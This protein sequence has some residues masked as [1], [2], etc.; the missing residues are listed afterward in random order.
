LISNANSCTLT[1]SHP[2]ISPDIFQH[3][4]PIISCNDYFSQFMHDQLNNRINLLKHGPIVCRSLKYDIVNSGDVRQY[5]TRVMRLTRGRLL[6]QDD[7][8]DW[9]TSKFLQLDQYADQKCFGDPTLVDKDDAVFHL[10]WT[11]NIKALD[12][13]KKALCVCDGSSRSGSLKILDEVYAN[14]IGQTS[15]RLFYTVLAAKNLLIFGSDVCNAFAEAPLPKQGF[16]I[17]PDRAFHKW[18]ENHLRRPPIP[19]GHVIPILLA[20]QGHPESPRLWEKHANAIL[21]ELGLTSTTHKP[22]LYSG[23]INS[24]CIIF[25]RQVH[26]FAIAAPNDWNANILLDMLNEKLTMPIKRQGPLDMF[27]GVDV[28]QTKDYVKVDYHTYINRMCSKYLTSWLN[29]VPLL[30]TRPTPL[31]L[32]GDWLKGFNA[33]TGLT[34]PKEQA[35]LKGSMQIKYCASIGEL[36]WAMTTC[37][38][39]IAFTSVKLSQLNSTPA[40]IHYH[41]LKHAI[42]YLYM[43][44]IDGIYFWHTQS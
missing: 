14:C 11:Y 1:F 44:R 21:R 23:L 28:T 15:S 17:R 39:D 42:R 6:K 31:P 32:D 33:P 30:E 37:R 7:W 18:W 19:P 13:R 38:P 16:H 9:Q 25:M 5:T 4:F 3:G 2:K 8:I 43:T 35:A 41:G 10:V 12:G 22:C 40:E 27:N 34:D 36:I 29:K 20:M 24:N 26:N